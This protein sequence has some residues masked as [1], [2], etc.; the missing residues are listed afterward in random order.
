[1]GALR[2]IAVSYPVL[3]LVII[4]LGLMV[5]CFAA[6]TAME[7]IETDSNGAISSA[8]LAIGLALWLGVA[9]FSSHGV[10]RGHDSSAYSQLQ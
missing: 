4:A 1:M 10:T 7:S 2:E 6:R 3:A 9:L 5:A 8:A